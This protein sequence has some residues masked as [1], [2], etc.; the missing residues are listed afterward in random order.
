MY[1]LIMM[2]YILTHPS[3]MWD[4][5]FYIEKPKKSL[6]KK[7]EDDIEYLREIL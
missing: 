5:L 4:N 7:Q 3:I 1:Y 6:T 2:K